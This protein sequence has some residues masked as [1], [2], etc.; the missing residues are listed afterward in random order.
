VGAVIGQW[1]Q[2]QAAEAGKT[3]VPNG[4]DSRL[5]AEFKQQFSAEAA[6]LAAFFTNEAAVVRSFAMRIRDQAKRT[7]SAAV[8]AAATA[9]ATSIEI[10]SDCE[11]VDSDC[12]IVE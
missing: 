12:E 6:V 9:A 7:Q 8:P 1:E 5:F 10:L 2:Q 11:I 4:F 3:R